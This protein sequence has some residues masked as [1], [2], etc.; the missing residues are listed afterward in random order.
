MPINKG[1]PA[2][3]VIFNFVHYCKLLL[4]TKYY[5]IFFYYFCSAKVRHNYGK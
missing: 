2:I 4:V 3:F 5:V 1:F